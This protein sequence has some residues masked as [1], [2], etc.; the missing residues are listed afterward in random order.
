MTESDEVRV[1]ATRPRIV[2]LIYQSFLPTQGRFPRVSGQARVLRENG[3]DVSILACDRDASHPKSENV[4]G[5]L[6]ERIR[7]KTTEMRGPLGQL[8][9]LLRFYRKALKRLR[10]YRPDIL[11]CHNLDVLPIGWV[12]KRL[13]GCRLVFESHE[14]NYYALWPPILAPMIWL[15]ERIELFLARRCD[16]VSVTNQYQ[17]DKYRAGGCRKVRLIGNYPPPELRSGVPPRTIGSKRRL[18]LGRFGTYYPEVGLEVTVEA[19]RLAV[20]AGANVSLVL[21]GR[22]IDSYHHVFDSLIAS[23]GEHCSYVGAFEVARMRELYREIDISCLIYP[24]S[25]WFRNITPRKYFDSICNATPVMISDIGG[26]GA[27]VRRFECGVVVDPED[28]TGIAEVIV[29]LDRDRDRVR[30]MADNA[31]DLGL[32]EYSWERMGGIYSSLNRGL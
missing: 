1:D 26:L 4:G 14:P 13:T 16:A 25:R 24:Q 22:V 5:I 17:V 15:L 28:A 9:P 31:L 29:E 18:V 30:K 23:A 11:H 3:F 19:L 32:T 10:R 7:V 21:G 2:K 12:T 6:V 8:L 27:T 20:E